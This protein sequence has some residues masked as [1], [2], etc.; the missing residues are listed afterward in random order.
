VVRLPD[1]VPESTPMGKN[2]TQTCHAEQEN[3]LQY[4]NYCY[5]NRKYCCRDRLAKLTGDLLFGQLCERII[6]CGF[7]GRAV[8]GDWLGGQYERMSD[9]W[10]GVSREVN[11]LGQVYVSELALDA[12]LQLLE[13]G[14]VRAGK[15]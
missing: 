1:V 13:M 9:P 7:W 10:M 11:S 14:L 5:N 15:K 4:S 8:S 2:P 3:F 12:H 6:Q